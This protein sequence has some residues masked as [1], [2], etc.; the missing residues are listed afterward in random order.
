MTNLPVPTEIDQSI[1][2]DWLRYSLGQ[3]ELASP[4]ALRRIEEHAGH[5]YTLAPETVD[6]ARLEKPREGAV[7]TP[8][9]GSPREALA[10][11]L[12]TLAKRGAVCV[13][14]EDEVRESVT[15]NRVWTASYGRGS[16]V[17]W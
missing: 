7:I 4:L 12:A 6:R 13:V 14:V 1:A 11:V 5:A 9:T 17:K 3:G 16:L 8:G 15:R 2:L 10:R